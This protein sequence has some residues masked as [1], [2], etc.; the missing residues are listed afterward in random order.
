MEK[1]YY[2]SYNTYLTNLLFALENKIY[3]H[4]RSIGLPLSLHV[5]GAQHSAFVL[6]HTG[7]LPG[8]VVGEGV[9]GAGGGVLAL[10]GAGVT[11]APEG[12]EAH[13]HVFPPFPHPSGWPAVEQIPPAPAS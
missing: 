7:Q 11:G 9:V 6:K 8:V 3:L 2:N 1:R 5:L 13:Q 12:Q 4:P 10:V